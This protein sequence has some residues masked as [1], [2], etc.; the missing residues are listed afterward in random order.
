MHTDHCIGATRCQNT[1]GESAYFREICPLPPLL[2]GTPG[3]NMGQQ[4]YNINHLK[5]YVMWSL[6]YVYGDNSFGSV[7]VRVCLV[8][9]FEIIELETSFGMCKCITGSLSN[10]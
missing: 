7:H 10:V 4:A 3:K 9:T 6:P 5:F 8:A 2:M 1:G